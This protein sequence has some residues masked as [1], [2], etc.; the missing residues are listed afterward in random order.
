MKSI[1]A[2]GMLR[3][4]E[5]FTI[6]YIMSGKLIIIF[7]WELG[8]VIGMA[9]FG[10]II[11]KSDIRVQRKSFGSKHIYHFILNVKAVLCV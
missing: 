9:V 5:P 11:D 1:P 6:F 10:A 3:I 2:S 7:K 4:T 8:A